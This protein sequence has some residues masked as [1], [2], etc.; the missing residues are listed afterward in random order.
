MH[1]RQ[2][3]RQTT[4]TSFHGTGLVLPAR[5]QPFHF[6]LHSLGRILLFVAL[7]SATYV[8]MSE[9]SGVPI[10]HAATIVRAAPANTA[11]L[12]YKFDNSRT[13]QNPNETILNES[14]VNSSQFGKHVSYSVDG[15]VYAEPLYVPN[16]T[17]GGHAH[18]V[19]F[20]A[21]EHD[22]VYAFDADARSAIAPLWHSSFINPSHGITTIS[23]TVQNCGNITPEYGITG[24]PVID[25]SSNTLYVVASTEENGSFFQRLH[26]LDITTGNEKP[27]SGIAIKA[28]V[29]GTGSGSI[30]GVVHFDAYQHLQRPGL[31]LLNGVVYLA[32]GSH[33]DHDP[34]HGWVIGYNAT[35]LKKALNAVYNTTRNAARG[36][37]WQSGDGLAAD[38]V[39]NIY[40]M[41]GNG[42]FDANTGGKDYGDSVVKLATTNGLKVSDY[43]TPFNQE[44]LNGN[45]I[46]LGSGGPVL[47]PTSNELV[48]I[49]K[50]GRIYVISRSN[51][52]KYT[53]INN[54][55]SNQ[56]LTNVDKVLQESAP[57]TISGG[58]FST[59]VYWNGSTG[60]YIFT[61]GASD[62]VKAYKLTNGLLSSSPT[63]QT[64]ESFSFP[65]PNPFVSSNGTVANSGILWIIDPSHVLRAYPA[66]NLGRELFNSQLPGYEVF[67]TPTVANGEVFVGTSSTLEIYGL[68]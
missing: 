60:E 8:L 36:A 16:L 50:E 61:S 66:D 53:A 41:T 45:D 68:L 9:G 56:N 13:G 38:S 3:A 48:T 37:I 49:G 20:V 6:V 67:T 55:C 25:L 18:N 63:S 7:V 40:F 24:T 46:D 54:P 26:A 42:N 21:T 34:Y 59:P 2:M 31:L 33:C 65:G 58:A 64:P 52:G 1:T 17:I 28:Q 27:G 15:N 5:Q 32:F 44:C 22:S 11:V 57:G 47:L 14:N 4:G 19:V 30:N 62:H 23:S 39:G 51:M 43:F 29:K 12:T 10:T 35:T